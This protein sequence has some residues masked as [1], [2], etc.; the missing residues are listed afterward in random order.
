MLTRAPRRELRPQ[1]EGG[2]DA[3]PPYEVLDPS[4][5]E[6]SIEEDLSVEQIAARGFS[7]RNVAQLLDTW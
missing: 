2:A 3:L 1:P 5:L 4:S 7:R 6:A